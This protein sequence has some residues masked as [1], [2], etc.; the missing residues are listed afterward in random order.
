M[1][2]A[3]SFVSAEEGKLD[4]ME[5]VIVVEAML[6]EFPWAVLLV[7]DVLL[8]GG[9]SSDAIIFQN[10]GISR[11]SA[12]GCCLHRCSWEIMLWAQDESRQ[13]DVRL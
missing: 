6:F 8:F 5:V 11:A 4:R 7:F 12:H 3:L 1:C 9:F 10:V 2:V 13:S